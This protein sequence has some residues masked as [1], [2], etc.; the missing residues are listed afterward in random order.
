MRI[1]LVEPDY[2]RGSQSF[3]QKVANGRGRKRDDETLWYPPIGLMKI[4]TF[5]KGRGDHVQFVIGT[6]ASVI[7]KA[8]LFSDVEL[9]DRVYITTL[10]TFG[11][12]KIIETIEFYKQAVGGSVS[13]IFVGGIMASLMPEEIFTATNIYPI[14]GTLDSPQKI[15]LEGNEN[16]DEL[17]LDYE[18]LP[19][20]VYAINDTYYGYATRGCENKCS[21]CGVPKIE[22]DLVDYIDIKPSI[23]YLRRTYG[24]KS[25]LKLMDNNVLASPNLRKIVNDLLELGYGR[26]ETTD[27]PSPKAKVVDFNQG[28]D[29]THFTEECLE[30]I[31]KINIKPMRIAFDRLSEENDYKNAIRLARKYGFN[32]F[33]NYMLYNWKDTPRDLYRR[34]EINFELNEEYTGAGGIYSYPMRFAPI[35]DIDGTGANKNR[36]FFVDP[37]KDCDD[38]FEN[39]QWNRRFVRNVEIIKGAANGA[40]SPTTTL[41]RRAIGYDFKQFLANLY[42][43]EEL[44]RNR[45][46]YEATIRDGEPKRT[47]GDGTIEKFY[48]FIYRLLETQ[49]E[50]FLYFHD[51]VSQNSVKGIKAAIENCK[52]KEV[53]NWL[54]WYLKK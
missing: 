10:F 16:I 9:W 6:D 34:L 7:P 42:M 40:I 35:A 45:N 21:W 31:S 46:K 1:L 2:R 15:R 28:L 51:A 5:H 14:V 36:D 20:E 8:D 39:A 32:D 11:W 27:S 33:S 29:A 22:G 49:D 54:K 48:E 18:L 37:K 17:P 47:L 24:D 4:S 44:L 25:R 43:P 26:G 52:Y 12:N 13:K 38:Y 19:T 41:A 30:I 50:K 23:Y 3:R 53:E